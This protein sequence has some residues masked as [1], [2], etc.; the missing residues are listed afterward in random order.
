MTRC[1]ALVVV[2]VAL[3]AG[4]LL[5]WCADRHTRN[6]HTVE[7]G[8]L[9]RSGQLTPT[10]LKYA[11]RR[12][13]IRT[14]V[15]LRTVRDPSRPYPDQWEAEVCAAHGVRHV[16][17]VPRAWPV[18]EKGERPAE[19]MVREFLAVMNDPA[20]HPVLVHCFA[21]VHRTGTM[22]A[23]YRAEYHG[24]TAERAIAEMEGYGFAPGP[25][26]EAIEGYLRASRRPLR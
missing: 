10:G 24:W 8:V 4:G 2:V 20:N 1:R 9:Y 22:C 25:G 16:R 12:H 11:L 15:T 18:D 6:F 21:G 14:V 19:Q 3:A 26:R 23:V 5:A 17:V 7:P 13:R